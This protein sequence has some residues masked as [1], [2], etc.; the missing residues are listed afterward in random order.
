MNS[1]KT[2]ECRE[3]RPVEGQYA[4]CFQIGQNEFEFVIDFGQSY[5][6]NGKEHFHTRVV[7]TPHAANVLL[8]LLQKSVKEYGETFGNT[9][10]G[11]K[12]CFW[13]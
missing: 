7:C 2:D 12:R 1:N 8:K 10:E 9:E 3:N 13:Y 6:E 4:N 11:N 5:A